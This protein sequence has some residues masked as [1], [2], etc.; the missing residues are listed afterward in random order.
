M[1]HIVVRKLTISYHAVKSHRISKKLLYSHVHHMFTNLT[2]HGSHCTWPVLHK[3]LFKTWGCTFVGPHSR[4]A[5]PHKK[6]SE[7][8]L[9]YT[10]TSF[11]HK[12]CP[13]TRWT[14]PFS[15]NTTGYR[16][17][18]SMG[19]KGWMLHL[20]RVMSKVSMVQRVQTDRWMRDKVVLR[21]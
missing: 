4:S 17:C 1:Y 15:E 10:E 21:F 3:F 7:S 18:R 6:A 14:R 13:S 20:Y 11:F 16:C 5:I 8:P 9:F 19:K 2:E 12:R